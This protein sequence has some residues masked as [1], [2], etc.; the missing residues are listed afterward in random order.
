MVKTLIDM[1]LV[2][3]ST[4]HPDFS[5]NRTT[6]QMVIAN[7]SVDD[8]K[9]AR[10][11]RRQSIKNMN[12]D[13]EGEIRGA[14]SPRKGERSPRS[15]GRGGGGA[16]VIH[17]GWVERHET[18][19]MRDQLKRYYA[20]IRS[21]RHLYFYK[22]KEGFSSDVR[23]A[24]RYDLS[25]AGATALAGNEIKI[26]A[27]FKNGES[28]NHTIH[29]SKQTDFIKWNQMILVATNDKQWEAVTSARTKKK[30]PPPPLP[31][32]SVAVKELPKT[33]SESS[34]DVS[35]MSTN[36]S[37]MDPQAIV[38]RRLLGGYFNIIRKKIRD[39]V[40]RDVVDGTRALSFILFITLQVPK[41][42]MLC[43][44]EKSRT[45]LHSKL[46]AELY[47][48]DKVNEMLNESEEAALERE[49]VVG[50]LKH[51]D[52]AMKAIEEVRK[53]S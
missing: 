50:A 48:P 18:G 26:N 11:A 42:I 40:R 23:T 6:V 21:D 13:F 22:E 33:G 7:Q 41:A 37:S 24:E 32:K 38:I 53:F 45:K 20:A 15:G 3:I 51:M 39:S 10:R 36:E 4:D 35:R 29:I 9:E 8:Q 27:L 17:S 46:I 34:L 16:G 49:R 12:R 30:P 31:R 5:E 28:V 52:M 2:R 47:S 14:M 1:E 44:I 43:L 19:F 25:N